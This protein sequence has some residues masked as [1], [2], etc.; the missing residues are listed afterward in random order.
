MTAKKKGSTVLLQKEQVTRALLETAHMIYAEQA[1]DGAVPQSI[2]D[3][4]SFTL[5]QIILELENLYE[6]PLL[7]D[8]EPYRAGEG[9]RQGD[10]FEEL[11][12]IIVTI[13]ADHEPG[14]AGEPSSHARS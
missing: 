2:Q 1:D 3:V 6:I 13:A 11:A 8:L 14:H 12:G 4:D 9:Y 7:E 10:S 5:V